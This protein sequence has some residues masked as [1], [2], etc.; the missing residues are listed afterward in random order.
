MGSVRLNFIRFSQN[1]FPWAKKREQNKKALGK[2]SGPHFDFSD[3]ESSSICNVSIPKKVCFHVL[4][5][6]TY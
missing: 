1:E 4:Y 2:G 3:I 5:V 6:R